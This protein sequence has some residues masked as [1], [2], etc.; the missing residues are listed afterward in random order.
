MTIPNTYDIAYYTGAIENGYL[1]RIGECYLENIDVSYGGDK[2]TFH[3]A[4][5]GKG[6]SPTRITMTLAFKEM[7][8]ITKSLIQQGF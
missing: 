6:A 3:T 2:M 7:Q 4:A 5:A 1:H 8:T